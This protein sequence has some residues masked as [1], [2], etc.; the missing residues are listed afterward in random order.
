MAEDWSREEVEA[1]VADYF[2]M[3][4]QE[5]RGQPY[6]KTAHRRLLS[7]RLRNRSDG[8]I[9]RKHQNISAILLE[10]G[11]IPIRG[12]KP[13]SNYQGLLAD[14]VSA[15]YEASIALRKVLERQ[16]QEPAV[17]PS[18]EDILKVLVAPPASEAGDRFASWEVRER[19]TI[20]RGVDYAALE[21]ANR[22]LGV[23]GEEFVVRYEV[24]RLVAAR[25]DRLASLVERVSATQGDGARIRRA[26]L[27]RNRPGATHRSQDDRVRPIHSLLRHA[28]R[29]AGIARNRRPVLRLSTVRLQTNAE[30]VRKAWCD[31]HGFRS[32]AF[33]VRCPAVV[34][35]CL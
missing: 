15:R 32:R 21:A 11:F 24:A 29:V 18:V 3:L 25:E 13:A 35:A 9:E 12:Y 6:N 28:Q 10:L 27:R 19:G 22:S 17:L 33:A 8:A 7:V 16:V 30:D 34:I 31:R 1:T 2:D 23:A 20:R 14:V 26:L 5:L 4:D